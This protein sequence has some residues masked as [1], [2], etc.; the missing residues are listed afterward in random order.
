[1]SETVDLKKWY[2]VRA[3]SGQ[4]NKIRDYMESE[5]NRLGFNNLVEDILV[6]TQKVVQIRKGK[7][8]NKEKVYFPGYIMI[9]ANLAGEIPHIIKALPNVI[10]FLGETKGGD[11]IP[12]RTA[13]VNRMLGKVDELSTESESVSIPFEIGESI[14]VIDGPFNGFNGSIEKV[15]QEKR[16]LEVMVKIFGRKTPLELSYMQVEKI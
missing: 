12:L 13:E 9:K 15:N 6:P 7:K 10:G 4:E 8:I 1:M 5:I 3:V 11:P 2:V 14:K 16:K